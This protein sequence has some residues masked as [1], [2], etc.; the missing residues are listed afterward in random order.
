MRNCDH[1]KK[2]QFRKGGVPHNAGVYP[3]KKICAV[4]GGEFLLTVLESRTKKTCSK[5]CRYE[6]L[7]KRFSKEELTYSGL[8]QWI[9][10]TLGKPDTCDFCGKTGL[11]G[12]HIQWA[13]KSGKYQKDISDWI[14]LCVPCHHKLDDI[15][16]KIWDSRRKNNR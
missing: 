4:C 1:L 7:S 12:K 16:K 2:Y 13:N 11:T 3:K 10:R 8:H 9:S 6:L 15:H 14:R 5:K